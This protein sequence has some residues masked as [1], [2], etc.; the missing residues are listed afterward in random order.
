[1]AC[2]TAVV[3][4]EKVPGSSHAITAL[5]DCVGKGGCLCLNTVGCI[6]A[7]DTSANNDNINI[8]LRF[9]VCH[10]GGDCLARLLFAPR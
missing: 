9:G 6:Y 10:L 1:M 4:N 8:G 7:R 2:G 3:T 5:E